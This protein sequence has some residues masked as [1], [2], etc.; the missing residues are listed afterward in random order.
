MGRSRTTQRVNLR[1]VI[2]T[3]VIVLVL[4]I[5]GVFAAGIF[6]ERVRTELIR[7]T[8]TLVEKDQPRMAMRHLERF[9]EKHPNDVEMLDRFT[10]LLSEAVL[11]QGDTSRSRAAIRQ[12]ERLLRLDPDGNLEGSDR[13]QNRKWLAEL[14]I[15]GSGGPA[16]TAEESV[17]NDF[18]SNAETVIED[19][20]RRGADDAETYRLLGLA[21]EG[22][23]GTNR[24]IEPAIEA[25]RNAL[26]RDPTDAISAERLALLYRDRLNNPEKAEEVLDDLVRE[27]PDSVDTW[28]VRYNVFLGSDQP[29]LASAALTR[30]A[31]LIP[32]ADDDST[33]FRRVML[34]A[35]GDALARN[36]L[37]QAGSF[38]DRLSELHQALPQVALIRAS[39]DQRRGRTDQAIERLRDAVLKTQDEDL[40]WQLANVLIGSGDL[41]GAGVFVQRFGEVV[42][43]SRVSSYEMLRGKWQHAAGQHDQAIASFNRAEPGLMASQKPS[44]LLLRA[45]SKLKLG[46]RAA[47][48]DDLRAAV[49]L[50]PENPEVRLALV[51]ALVPEGADRALAE[52]RDAIAESPESIDLRVALLRSLLAQQAALPASRR[53]WSRFETALNDARTIEALKDDPA[54]ALLEIQRLQIDG[55]TDEALARLESAVAEHPKEVVFWTTWSDLL[56]RQNRFEEALAVL[57]RAS[58]PEAVGTLPALTLTQARLLS[59]LGRGRDAIDLLSEAAS[60]L[61]TNQR[62]EI[63]QALGRMHIARGQFDEARA[64][65]AAWQTLQPGSAIPLLAQL[66]LAIDTGDIP[67]AEAALQALRGPQEQPGLPYRLGLA[68]FLLRVPGADKLGRTRKALDTLAPILGDGTDKNPG[69]APELATALH[70]RGLAYRQLGELDT[71]PNPVEASFDLALADL[72]SAWEKGEGRALAPMIDLLVRLDRLDEIDRL[73]RLSSTTGFDAQIDRLAAEACL[74]N[75]RLDLAAEY[76][77]RAGQSP[78]AST[79][80]FAAWRMAMYDRLGRTAQVEQ[81]LRAQ[82]NDRRDAPSW[83]ALI[84]YLAARGQPEAAQEAIAS[85]KRLVISD[86]PELLEAQAQEAIGKLDAA[87]ASYQAALEARPDDPLALLLAARFDRSVGR[88]E[89]ALER[90]EHLLSLEPDSR[91][92][93]RFKALILADQSTD[94]DSWQAAWDAL[95]PEPSASDPQAPQDRMARAIVLARHPEASRREEA[96]GRLEALIADQPAG[97]PM[98]AAARETL[99]RLLLQ[100]DR[101]DRAAEVA[102]VTAISG[103]NPTA[104]ALYT[105]ALID[106]G[107]LDEA[108]RQ[109]DRLRNLSAAPDELTDLDLRLVEARAEAGSV[110]EELERAYF[111]AVET[112]N[113]IESAA[114]TFRRLV[115]LGD[116]TLEPTERVGRD[117]AERFPTLAWM[118]SQWF[119]AR[120]IFPEALALAEP[121]IQSD[122]AVAALQAVRGVLTVVDRSKAEP[123]LM[124]RA[125]DLIEQAAARHDLP[126]IKAVLAMLRHFQGRIDPTR[127]DDEIRIYRELLQSEPDNVVYLNNL[128]WALSEYAEQPG[129][130][131]ELIDRALA[132]LD[133]RAPELLDTRAVI[134]LRLDRLDEAR[135]TLDEVVRER[136]NSGLYRFHLARVLDQAGDPDA[137]RESFAKAL[138]LGLTVDD[139]DPFER[140]AFTTLSDL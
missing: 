67:G 4:V 38:L 108:G 117:L 6:R 78:S 12:N 5:G 99:A 10:R 37:D 24:P 7:Q 104:V 30:A 86:F 53:S 134:L 20:I 69:L 17:A 90:V 83:I 124:A 126:A 82:A 75:G 138:E 88:S 60:T 43:E 116:S 112:D 32:E 119:A 65:F 121:A 58:S 77:E 31:D 36:E 81:M 123:E 79:P 1:A 40:I 52:L 109:L 135:T 130:A 9:L 103:T 127:F 137:A 128:A 15:R 107:Q 63:L 41:T 45:D 140:D 48:L 92:A 27:A 97:D 49:E 23:G 11:E 72:R 13:Q 50:A 113:A 91:P 61:P 118:P 110:A 14:Y 44:L 42:S 100:M 87:D 3:T 57:E 106:A 71:N 66:E 133:V 96:V 74:R 68:E 25:Y 102:A 139:L 59:Q 85:M 89:E 55:Q 46:Q 131:L 16:A 98:T 39:I 122:D 115:Q 136:P 70:L 76:V 84:R 34:A 132:A 95:G 8:E 21:R 125:S 94:A 80:Q 73:P 120:D 2:G 105:R 64:A 93:A 114:A 56:V 62:P 47:A 129:E 101:P 18:S 26:E 111:E 29:E 33:N 54:L 22:L 28:L 19:L 35:S 51:Q